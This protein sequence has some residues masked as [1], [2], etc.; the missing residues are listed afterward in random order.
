MWF[1]P[2]GSSWFHWGADGQ[3]GRRWHPRT[4]ASPGSEGL[5]FFTG[6]S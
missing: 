6:A 4:H 1:Q 5:P 3:R 2:P